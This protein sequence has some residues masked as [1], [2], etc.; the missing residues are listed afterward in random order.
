MLKDEY[1]KGIFLLILAIGGNNINELLGCQVQKLF[2][3][4]MIAK[5]FLTFLTIFFAIDFSTD[6][7]ENPLLTFKKATTIYVLFVLSS[8]MN[9]YFSILSLVILSIIYFINNYIEYYI[10]IDKKKD[11]NTLKDIKDNLINIQVII[12]II[13]FTLYFIKQ[14]K[15]KK[16]WNLFKF[17]FGTIKCI[18]K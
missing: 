8:R 5:H 17:I 15:E 11:I 1:I 3:K 4:N 12:I 18:N 16:N 7:K 14:K 6:E 2:E 13:G 10:A 9:V